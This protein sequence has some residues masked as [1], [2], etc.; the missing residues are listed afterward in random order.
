M[1]A[2]R[3]LILVVTTLVMGL[4]AC[5]ITTQVSPEA[6]TTLALAS[7]A[8]D[9]ALLVDGLGA[10]EFGDPADLVIEGVT[11]TVG[12]WDA[13][14]QDSDVGTT[15]QCAT[16][17]ARLVLWGSL[18]LTFVEQDGTDIFTG[19]TYGF[20]PLTG[21]SDDNRHLGLTTPEGIGLGSQ[22]HDLVDAYGS[23]VSIVDDAE[24]D[25]A[26]FEVTSPGSTQ[27]AGKLDATDST[28]SVDFLE[29]TP[30]C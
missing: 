22:R 13:D 12:G 23:N 19:W 14:S 7:P 25:T 8:S 21:N 6:T 16:G 26:T 2:S 3:R 24:L 30:S 28:G 4:S 29:T 11:A 10:F 1:H 27:L 17:S 18:V 20:D 15:P 5:S 9:L